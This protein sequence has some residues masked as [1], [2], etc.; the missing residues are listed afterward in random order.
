[1]NVVYD[2]TSMTFT[3]LFTSFYTMGLKVSRS[4]EF[5]LES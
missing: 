5:D 1:M 3:I 4:I 2:S